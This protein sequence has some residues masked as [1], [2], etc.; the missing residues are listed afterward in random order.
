[1]R[2]A[3]IIDP[4]F[5]SLFIAPQIRMT[6]ATFDLVRRGA[7]TEQEVWWKSEGGNLMDIEHSGP[8]RTVETTSIG[9]PNGFAQFRRRP[10]GSLPTGV[11]QNPRWLPVPLV[12]RVSNGVS[13][14]F[15]CDAHEYRS[16]SETIAKPSG[17][18]HHTFLCVTHSP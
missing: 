1:M 12:L 4:I 17:P 3:W 14:C 16:I 7:A 8:R 11:A 10:Y 9:F 18:I 6:V 2:D 13:T 15:H 5:S